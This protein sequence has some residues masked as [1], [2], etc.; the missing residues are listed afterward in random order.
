MAYLKGWVCMYLIVRPS[1]DHILFYYV[2]IR[3][4][5]LMTVNRNC[6]M[7]FFSPIWNM[8]RCHIAV[9]LKTKGGVSFLNLFTYLGAPPWR[10]NPCPCYLWDWEK[11]GISLLLN[12]LT[13]QYLVLFLIIIWL[14]PL[15][16]AT[17]DT[18]IGDP[19]Y[20]C[21]FW[22]DIQAGY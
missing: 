13:M 4:L 15:E 16:G 19:C 2:L 8:R 6:F 7:L 20:F 10:S 18:R 11:D 22:Y 3:F 1:K 12:W 21:L 14:S 9:L 5:F 17:C